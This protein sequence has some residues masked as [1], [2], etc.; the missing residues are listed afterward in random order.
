MAAAGQHQSTCKGKAFT[1]TG[2]V[3]AGVL[4]LLPRF[5]DQL[6]LCVLQH[7]NR[8]IPKHPT[9]HVQ[10][11]ADGAWGLGAT[12]NRHHAKVLARLVDLPDRGTTSAVQVELAQV[13]KHPQA[14]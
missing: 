11:T 12:L 10:W 4:R 5:L 14:Q 1:Q 9:P 6:K 2:V 8:H 13:L 3:A 7:C